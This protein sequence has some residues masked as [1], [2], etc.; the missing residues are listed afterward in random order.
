MDMPQRLSLAEL[1]RSL[2]EAIYG[3]VPD[4][5]A[6]LQPDAVE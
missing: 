5:T 1:A 6:E 3:D 4:V 2:A